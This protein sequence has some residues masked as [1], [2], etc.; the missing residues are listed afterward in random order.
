ME[1]QAKDRVLTVSAHGQTEILGT[2]MRDGSASLLIESGALPGTREF[3]AVKFERAHRTKV[4]KV[5]V[6]PE[7][8]EEEITSMGV[9][10]S[11]N[12]LICLGRFQSGGKYFGPT[13]IVFEAGKRTAT[14]LRLGRDDAYLY[15][16]V[17]RY[18][19]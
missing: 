3:P 1:K 2:L 6:V 18:L 16:Q 8:V 19:L 7:V 17:R 14:A 11:P 15:D 12:S 10:V 4:A 9:S 5:S 13:L